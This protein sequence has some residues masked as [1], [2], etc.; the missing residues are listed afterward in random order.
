MGISLRLVNEKVND[1]RVLFPSIKPSLLG[2][3]ALLIDVGLEASIA[4]ALGEL[5]IA[6]FVYDSEANAEVDIDG[7]DVGVV[8]SGGLGLV[9][10]ERWDQAADEDDIIVEVAEGNEDL[11]ERLAGPRKLFRGIVGSVRRA[12]EASDGGSRARG[13]RAS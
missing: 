12:H 11:E 2:A 7:A 9:D 4:E 10:E 13:R 5:V 8:A 3:V 6:I 1:D